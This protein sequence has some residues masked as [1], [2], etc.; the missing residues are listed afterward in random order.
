MVFTEELMPGD[1]PRRFYG[2]AI[3]ISESRLITAG[4]VVTGTRGAILRVRVSLPGV[5]HVDPGHLAKKQIH[6]IECTPIKNFYKR[7]RAIQDPPNPRDIAILDAGSY[8]APSGRYLS[9]I[10][11]SIIPPPKSTIDVVGYPGYIKPDWIDAHEGLNDSN[12]GQRD[13]ESLLPRGHLTVTR[14]VAHESIGSVFRY[15]ISTCPGMSGGCVLF[16]G[17][18]IGEHSFHLSDLRS[19]SR[20]SRQKAY[21]P[22]NGALIYGRNR[23]DCERL[24]RAG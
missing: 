24:Y 21:Q 13:A 10:A 4:H 15:N 5:S 16:N 7:N 20:A 18:V 1:S 2:T 3:W 9:S 19:S 14:G 22:A 6:S 23:R 11:G 12:K 17:K 8:K